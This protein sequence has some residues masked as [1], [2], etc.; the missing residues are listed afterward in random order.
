MSGNLQQAPLEIILELGGGR[1]GFT[2]FLQLINKSGQDIELVYPIDGYMDLVRDDIGPEYICRI[3]DITDDNQPFV[4]PVLK[5]N[6]NKRLTLIC[7][8]E[9]YIASRIYNYLNKINKDTALKLRLIFSILVDIQQSKRIIKVTPSYFLQLNKEVLKNLINQWYTFYF[10]AEALPTAIP[11]DVADNYFEAIR[12]FNAGAY[13]ASAVMARRTLEL[14]LLKKG[15][16]TTKD[17]IGRFVESE[18]SKP[19]NQRKLSSKLLALLDAVRVFG[20]YGAHAWDDNL[21]DITETD[22]R[23]ALETLKKALIELFSA[24]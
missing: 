22:T 24:P 12:S 1:R 13:R 3:L 14:A 19:I 4:T 8:V 2:I 16:I 20:D 21:N 23:L 7:I 11:L 5:Q 9:P 15:L 6:E 10:E 17:T 18:K